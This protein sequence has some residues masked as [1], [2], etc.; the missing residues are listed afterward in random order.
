M[1]PVTPTSVSSKF[2]TQSAGCLVVFL[3]GSDVFMHLRIRDLT[4]AQAW[5]T[6]D[7]PKTDGSKKNRDE[8]KPMQ[9]LQSPETSVDI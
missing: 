5:A 7:T 3:G 9:T 8:A 6:P 2:G 1:S 4:A